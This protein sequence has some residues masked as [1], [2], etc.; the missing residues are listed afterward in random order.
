M[1][2]F[3]IWLGV[4]LYTAIFISEVVRAGIMAVSKGQSE[5]GLSLGLGRGALLRLIVL[6]QAIRVMLPPMGKGLRHEKARKYPILR[7]CGLGP[8][9]TWIFGT[10]P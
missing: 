10:E 3:A 4:V 1:G 5:A 8:F 2:Y 9:G 7:Q 6:P